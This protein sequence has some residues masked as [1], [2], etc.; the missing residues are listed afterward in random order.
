M[1]TT[2]HLEKG[3]RVTALS[4]LPVSPNI[5]LRAVKFVRGP[6][7]QIWDAVP[8]FKAIVKAENLMF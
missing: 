3:G 5:D 1:T 6:L 4:L 2:Y 8:R 7:S